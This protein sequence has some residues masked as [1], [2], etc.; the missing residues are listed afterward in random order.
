MKRILLFLFILISCKEAYA[1]VIKAN[2]TI[3]EVTVFADR[4]RISRVSKIE[5][6]AGE[7]VI[8]LSGLSALIDP[9]SIRV[10]GEGRFMIGAIETKKEV[11]THLAQERE[12]DLNK[13]IEQLNDQLTILQ[14]EL[15]AI[16]Q[17]RAFIASLGKVSSDNVDKELKT[18]DLKPESW[19]KAWQQVYKGNATLSKDEVVK[20][21]K[22]EE[23]RAEIN[24]YRRELSSVYTG[25]KSTLRVRI[26]VEAKSAAKG[27]IKLTYLMGNAYWYPVYDL[28][29]DT[30]DKSVNILQYGAIAQST[31][32]DWGDVSVKLSTARPHVGTQMP[33]ID[34]Y[35]LNFLP[36]AP[37]PAPASRRMFD[38]KLSKTMAVQESMA[39]NMVMSE[40]Y[41]ADEIGI[42]DAGVMQAEIAATDYMAEFKIPGR[43]SI[44]ADNSV[45][46]F[47]VNS[48][49]VTVELAAQ[50]SPKLDTSAYLSAKMVYKG[51]TPLLPG[52]ATLFRDDFLIGNAS[53]PLVRSGEKHVMFFGVDDKIVIK[54][55]VM[56]EEK[57]TS[58]VISK[59][60]MI[61]KKYK[62]EV[63]N[64]HTNPM[65]IAIFD[66][67]PV[68]ANKDIVVKIDPKETTAG[69][70]EDTQNVKGV[71][72]WASEYK[73][74]EKKTFNFG[75]TVTYPKDQDLPSF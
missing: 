70:E 32:E 20:R 24:R 5:L 46:K 38:M 61:T 13:K 10:E 25:Q 59:D 40:D 60:N 9:Q 50:A 69:Y 73:P 49:D 29:L 4:A 53:I 66:Q 44:P 68:A 43:I 15:Q 21:R 16:A 71:L 3:D 52:D 51:E 37:P 41:E 63:Q 8:E 7:S 57:G 34:T 17:A 67:V 27:Q 6:P 54:R 35:W 2:S 74:K 12:K 14:G 26:N 19:E 30:Q 65:R 42:E 75:Y 39:V 62:M 28:R 1:A 64:L 31:G 45:Q 72:K 56:A 23:V 48:T 55:N 58:G 47:R 22:M 18:G 33:T 11:T 36:K